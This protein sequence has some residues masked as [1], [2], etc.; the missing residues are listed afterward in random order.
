MIRRRRAS[1][2]R[3]LKVRLVFPRAV[4]RPHIARMAVIL[5]S[6][7][8]L[9]PGIQSSGRAQYTMK[10]PLSQ[11]KAPLV[12]S[13]ALKGVRPQ[14]VSAAAMLPLSPIATNS[15]FSAS[16]YLATQSADSLLFAYAFF[17]ARRTDT[18]CSA[19][20]FLSATDC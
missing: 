16:L 3:S 4:N 8:Y 2:G 20:A 6:G 15:S 14:V 5:A 12:G 13:A 7:K 17:S 10:K 11:K 9:S 1:L 19:C 18:D